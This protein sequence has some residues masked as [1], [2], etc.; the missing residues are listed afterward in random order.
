MPARSIA[1]NAW[2]VA[3]AAWPAVPEVA[4]LTW[5]ARGKTST[6]IAIILGPAKPHRESSH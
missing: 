4:C 1:A 3:G 2:L 6:E 5:S